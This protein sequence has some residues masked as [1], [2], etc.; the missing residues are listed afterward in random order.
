MMVRKVRGNTQRQ[1]IYAGASGMLARAVDAA[2]S[3]AMPSIGHRMRVARMKSEALLAFEAATI[4]RT[5]PMQTSSSADGEILADLKKLR[6]ISRNTIRDDAHGA[7]AVSIIEENVVGRGI[8]PQSMCTPESTGMTADQC[9][10]WRRDCESEWERWSDEDADAT[11]Q[12]TFYDLQSLAIRTTVADGEAL[13]HAVISDGRMSCEMIDSDRIESEGGFDTVDVRGGVELGEAGEAVAFHVLKQHPD[14]LMFRGSGDRKPMRIVVRDGDLRMLTHTFRRLRPGQTRG[15]P[16]LAS[17]LSYLQ[18]LHHYLNSELIAARAASNYAMF[19]KRS[20]SPEDQDVLPVQG[21][22]VGQHAD[23]HE[24]LEAGT[25]EYLN[26]GEEPVPY[27]PNRPGSAFEPFVIRV[28]RAIAAS[29]GM[30]YEVVAKDFGR[31]NLSSARALLRE[32]QRAYDK[33]RQLFNRQWN[34]P[35]WENV[36]RLAVEA[37]RL[38]PPAKFLDNPRAFLAVRWVAPSYG[39]VDPVTDVEG[40]VGA[41]AA[42]LSTPYEEAARQGMDAESVLRDR[43]RFLKAA[44]EIEAEFG[45]PDGALTTP[46]AAAA[47][48]QAGAAGRD[49]KPAAAAD[50][51]PD[52]APADE[53]NP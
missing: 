35:W 37:G 46:A 2:V 10:Q 21:N 17:A 4:S 33:A 38:D 30:A 7:S 27:N 20:V 3:I 41:I 26:E 44:A 24:F 22:E 19:I 9:E 51:N 32:C 8:K 14:D 49:R 42:N 18:H 52:T 15:V 1:P 36:I 13:G 5:N 43:A 29:M 34:T 23:Y 31:M 6:D 40:S 16:W 12:G 25:I 11:R 48:A 47:P 28:L 53:N 50:S 39:M 45:L